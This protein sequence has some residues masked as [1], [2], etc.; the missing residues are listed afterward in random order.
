[1]KKYFGFV[2]LL[3]L[4]ISASLFVGCGKVDFKLN[5]IVDGEVRAT[6]STNGEELIKLPA[7]PEKEGYVFDGWYW[8]NEVWKRPFTANSLL[9]TPLSSDM[10]VYAKFEKEEAVKGTQAEFVGFEKTGENKYLKKVSNDT[11]IFSLGTSVKVNS[12]SSWQLSSDVYGNNVIASKTATLSVGDNYYYVNVIADDGTMQ[13][14]VLNIR[15]REIYTV[16][17]AD[18]DIQPQYIEEDSCVVAPVTANRTGYTFESWNFDFTAPIVEN[19]IINAK[20]NVVTYN[21]EYE[22][23]GGENNSENPTTYTIESEDIVL[24]T[25][26][27]TGYDFAGWYSDSRFSKRYY[28]IYSGSYDNLTL[29]AKWTHTVYRIEY[30]LNGGKNNSLNPSRYTIESNEI[31]LQ[32][33]SKTGYNFAGWY[34]DET[35]SEKVE[36]I[37]KGTLGRKKFYAKWTPTVYN[38]EYEL[39]GGENNVNNLTTYTIE[40]E[41]IVLEKPTKLDYDFCGWYLDKTFS[42]S[43]EKIEKG[44][45]GYKKL[46]A[47]WASVYYLF[48]DN[49]GTITG[50]T[51]YGKTCTSHVIP[52]KIND[53]TVRKIGDSA[54]SACNALTSI[55]IPDSVETIGEKSFAYC[56]GLKNVTVGTGLLSIGENAFDDDLSLKMVNYTGSLSQWCG[57]NGLKYIMY[58]VVNVWRH[59]KSETLI[60]SPS[61][62][63]NNEKI[64]GNLVIPNDVEKVSDYA[65]CGCSEITSITIPNSV[66]NIGDSAFR[67]CTGIENIYINDLTAWCNVS[68]L[69]NLMNYGSVNKKLYLNNELVT[70]LVIPDYV[71]NIAYSS[72]KN[73]SDIASVIVP[74]S[75]I[76]IGLDAFENCNGLANVEIGNSVKTIYSNAFKNCN[77]ITSLIIPDSIITIGSGAFEN[78]NGLANVAIGSSVKTIYSNAFKN[79]GNITSLII[80]DSVTTI[81]SSSFKN[82]NSLAS[83]TM[84]GNVDS[85]G[86]SAFYGCSKLTSIIIP[87]SVTSIGESAFDNCTGLTS[88][89]IGKNVVSIGR[90]YSY[91]YVGA[92]SNCYKLVEV[93]NN[94][95][96]KIRKGYSGMHNVAYYSL[97]VKTNGTSDIIN[98]NNY[99]FYTYENVNYLLGYIGMDTELTLPNDY[100]GQMY[101][102]YKY[103][104]YN[105]N[106]LTSVIIPNNVAF[107]GDYAFS[108]CGSLKYNE[109]DNAYYLGNESNK[110][111]VLIKAKSK[112]ITSCKINDN[113]K[114]VYSNA[115]SCCEKLTSVT[116]PNGLVSMGEKVFEGCEK[117]ASV[118]IPSSVT[119]IGSNAF[120][121]CS[122]LKFNEYDNAYYLGNSTNKYVWLIKAKSTSITG[123]N[124]NNNCIFIYSNAFL[125]CRSLDMFGGV[126][127]PDKVIAIGSNAFKNCN[128]INI[129]IP[130]S[131]TVIGDYAFDNSGYAVTI[132]YTG[133]KAEWNKIKK[134]N[135]LTY[136]VVCADGT[137]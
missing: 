31:V 130:N 113:C 75:I 119:T 71:T 18:C 106:D 38:I 21:I 109:Y 83:V 48:D 84:G 102:I 127:I 67:D 6:I 22:L 92:F 88:V 107:V 99:L 115:F 4:A 26:S 37:E 74:D 29:Y 51:D 13:L 12:K 65:F 77:S 24:Q 134:G 56:G 41:D 34:A 72:F 78:C 64:E 112:N 61:L 57:L 62:Y 23:N 101:E 66:T 108:G 5:F 126:K 47:K 131:V 32:E 28:R 53:I 73:C 82:C 81:G 95:T 14:Y 20:W 70:K 3:V 30:E 118:T 27:K 68:G 136:T 104:F 16:T 1:M 123:C 89:T 76:T 117:L 132:R 43:V 15:R 58:D 46:Y 111:V 137:I 103:A 110:Y 85:I 128:G 49:N 129:T 52:E 17:F 10:S 97:K 90:D 79:C 121:K 55:I 86:E 40:S 44:S 120:D 96:L 124:I 42:V 7:N 36:K 116:I 135:N 133:T 87:D 105:N 94:S 80:P 2:L 8:D 98:K 69:Y 11:E 25:P 50:L 91:Y 100:N 54:F 19:T 63:I 35:F 33:A 9:D 60:I 59:G 93:I 125:G 45:F 114:Y 122:S 39:N